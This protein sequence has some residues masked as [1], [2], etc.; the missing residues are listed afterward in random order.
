MYVILSASCQTY[1]T[2]YHIVLKAEDAVVDIKLSQFFLMD[3]DL[4]LLLDLNYSG[5]NL[6]PRGIRKLWLKKKKN[7]Y[8]SGTII[9]HVLTKEEKKKSDSP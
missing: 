2:A 9:L 5:L 6:L 1:Q 3:A 7:Q 4:V 8:R